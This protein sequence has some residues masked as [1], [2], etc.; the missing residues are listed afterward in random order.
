MVSLS[1]AQ[2]RHSTHFVSVL[3]Y[4]DSLYLKGGEATRF[5]LELFDAERANIEAGWAC[6]WKK[7]RKSL[8]A[9]L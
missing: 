2:M 4:A 7:V 1:E 6:A 3:R 8:K 9:A 5:G